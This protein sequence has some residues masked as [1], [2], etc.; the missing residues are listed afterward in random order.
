VNT[1]QI[2]FDV[3]NDFVFKRY[4]PIMKEIKLQSIIFSS[5]FPNDEIHN[6]AIRRNGD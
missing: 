1:A 6:L 4:M 3:K 2:I 5:N